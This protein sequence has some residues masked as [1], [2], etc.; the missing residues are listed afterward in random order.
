MAR[1]TPSGLDRFFFV[2]SGS[3]GTGTAVT[4]G[5]CRIRAN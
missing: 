2:D 5:A 1:V 4:N 3:A